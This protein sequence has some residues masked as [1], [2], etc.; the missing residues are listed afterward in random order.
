MPDSWTRNIPL[1]TRVLAAMSGGVDSSVAARR[2]VEAGFDVIGITMHL[3]PTENRPRSGAQVSDDR[4]CCSVA[5]AEDARRVAASI[6]I[7]HYIL[8]LADEFEE[9]VMGPTRNEYARG[10]TPNPCVLCNRYMKFDVLFK[11]AEQLGC[12]HVA[13][14]HYAR[15]VHGSD[16]LHLLRGIDPQKDQSYFLSFLT[17]KELERIIFPLGWETKESVREEAA[18]IGLK[19]A[20]RP[21]SQDLCFLATGP[22]ESSYLHADKKPGQIVLTDGTV[23]GEHNAISGF[24][25]GQRKGVPGGMPEKMYVVGID[26]EH[27]RVIVGKEEDLY[28]SEFSIDD[29]SLVSDERGRQA[30]KDEVDVQVRYRTEAVKGKVN[31]KTGGVSLA[32]PVRAITPGQAA[33]FYSGEEVIGGS[34]IEE[35]D[36]GERESSR[37]Q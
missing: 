13:T 20:D 26:A 4:A 36:S 18:R 27:N 14:G 11:R 32:K 19:V 1:G 17:E 9:K 30:L 37:D 3:V 33:V 22:V 2:L 10:R 15:I 16:G 25:I 23:I 7:P 28:S 6:G 31:L 34:T 24:T 5:A 35:V 8:N 21:E 29:V 12:T